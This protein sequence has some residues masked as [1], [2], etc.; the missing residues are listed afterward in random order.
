M[1]RII[2]LVDMSM[3]FGYNNLYMVKFM[4]KGQLTG[5]YIPKGIAED[6]PCLE[7]YIERKFPEVY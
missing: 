7:S 4:H 5:M 6:G 2:E 3:N 1:S